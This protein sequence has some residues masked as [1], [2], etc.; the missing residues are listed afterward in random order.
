M[1]HPR[2]A[3]VSVLLPACLP[4][5][6]ACSSA[7]P[8][9]EPEAT[10][11]A[12]GATRSGGSVGSATGGRGGGAGNASGGAS[13]GSSAQGGSAGS[14][15]GATGSGGASGDDA[16]PSASGGSAGTDTSAPPP[17]DDAA[18]SGPAPL[19]AVLAQFTAADVPAKGPMESAAPARSWAAPATPPMTAG[20]GL[21]QHPFLYA[22]EGFNTI[23]LVNDGKLI[24]SYN[25]APGGE[26]DDVWMLSNGHV[27]YSHSN[28]LEELTPKKEV[29]FHYDLP[30]GTESHSLQ[31]IGLDKVLFVANG[32]PAKIVI[33]N[34]ATKMA[35]VEHVITDAGANTHPQFRR[36]RMTA[37]GTY[38]APYLSQR[39][40]V[41]FDKDFK[42]IWNYPVADM[43]T[44]W[45]ALRL[46]NG[47][48]LI[49]DEHNKAAR[50][51]NPKMEIVW[52]FKPTDLPAGITRGS[53]QTCERLA[54]GNTVM[55]SPG[56][57]VGNAQAVEVNQAKE[58]VWVL[59]DWK[60]LGPGTTGQ[61]LDQPGIPEKPGDLI[62]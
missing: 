9:Q 47:N 60:N 21:A 22:G 51:V 57:N 29:V 15:G 33:M 50:E 35:E 3:L 41:E 49:Q 39:K 56:K 4:F 58:V 20:K 59:Q 54:N 45:S 6:V 31:P 25:S 53:P 11:G 27:L 46:A 30:A 18:P 55:F 1:K 34:K 42:I 48:T 28:F 62:H 2:R 7:T 19:M 32:Q 61:F 10:G 13:G 40:V 17:A 44:P 16:A 8:A 52:E 26:I 36:I 43:G 37:A 24:W 12:G 14:S 5:F 23:F 38:L